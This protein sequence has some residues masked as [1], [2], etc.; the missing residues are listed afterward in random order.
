MSCQEMLSQLIM[1][2][3]SNLMILLCYKKQA[4]ILIVFHFLCFMLEVVYVWI[5]EVI[6]NQMMVRCVDPPEYLE[7]CI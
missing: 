7:C 6:C 5:I 1:I 3:N 4:T 2:Y